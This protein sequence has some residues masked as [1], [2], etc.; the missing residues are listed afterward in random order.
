MIRTFSCEVYAL[1]N[2]ARLKRLKCVDPPNVYADASSKIKTSLSGRFLED[3]EVNWLADE[4]QPVMLIDG[5]EFPAGVFRVASVTMTLDGRG[6]VL[7]V[8]AYDRG[9]LLQQHRTQRIIHLAS[10]TNYIDAIE[11]LMAACGVT[12]IL[13]TPSS[14]T[15][16]TDREDWEVG[17]NYLTIV[18][19]LLGEINYREIWFDSTGYAVLEPARAPSADNVKHTYVA[20]TLKSVTARDC[21]AETDLFNKPNIFVVMC[22]N[23]D[24]EDVMVATAENNSPAS[25]TSTVS[26]GVRITSVAKV[27]NIASQEA[28][29]A[30]AEELR[31]KSMLSS[32]TVTIKTAIMPNHGIGDTVAL[33]HPGAQG[34]YEETGWYMELKAG[35]YMSHDLRKVVYL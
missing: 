15:L 16:T 30:Y 2:G 9:Y 13:K 34:I 24:M 28:L 29:Q 19:Q 18:N 27:D 10:G 11:A 3:G 26:R 20:G 7:E 21:V 31:E 1:R 33:N 6:R 17:T 8:E 12:Q 4:L 25:P 23:P 35:E 5:E 22:A 32:E 14:Y